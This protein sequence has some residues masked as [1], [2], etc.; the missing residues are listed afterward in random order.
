MLRHVVCL[1]WR[2][3]TPP[4]TIEAIEAAL[5]TLPA[6]IPE[7]RAYSFARDLGL[8]AGN[9]DFGIVADFDDADAWRTYQDD[10]EHQRIIAELIRPHLA[11]RT[12]TQFT[13]R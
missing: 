7:I 13:V 3:D 6:R 10:P 5:G 4:G 9:A 2:D 1:T 12:A 11:S 8:A